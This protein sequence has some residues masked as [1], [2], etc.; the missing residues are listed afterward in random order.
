[1]NA[2]QRETLVKGLKAVV[3]CLKEAEIAACAALEQPDVLYTER[4][5]QLLRMIRDTIKFAR[6]EAR[7]QQRL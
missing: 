4:D 7:R 3:E 2:A 1:M 6:A 5:Q